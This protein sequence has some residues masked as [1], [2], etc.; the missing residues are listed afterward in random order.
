MSTNPATPGLVHTGHQEADLR[1]F[2]DLDLLRDN[3]MQIRVIRITLHLVHIL[4]LPGAHQEGHMLLL[5]T[6]LPL[7]SLRKGPDLELLGGR[8]Q[9][10]LLQARE[11]VGRL[12]GHKQ[13]ED[14]PLTIWEHPTGLR[15]DR[16]RAHPL[17]TRST[18]R[19]ASYSSAND[20][21]FNPDAYEDD[22][23]ATPFAVSEPATVTK[24]TEWT[25]H[26]AGEGKGVYYYNVKTGESTWDKPPGL[27]D[28]VVRAAMST[29]APKPI[30]WDT[31]E[32][33]EWQEV[34]ISDGKVYYYNSSTQA[35]SWSV[36][37][38]VKDARAA[39]AA[40][41]LEAT[42]E[43]LAR[44]SS[45]AEAIAALEAARRVGDSPL[46]LVQRNL[47][48]PAV[49]VTSAATYV[50][51]EDNIV[52]EEV[53]EQEE[54][55]QRK[56][57]FRDM[58][59]ERGVT[60]FSRW[61]KELPKIV[62]DQRYKAIPDIKERRAIFDHFVRN[63]AEEVR[64]E[65]RANMKAAAENF[66]ALLDETE[67]AGDL[68][69]ET[70][71]ETLEEKWGRDS[72]WT[73][74]EP[75]EREAQL[76]ERLLPVK[77]A[78]EERLGA[79]AKVAEAGFRSMLED[80]GVTGSSRWSKMKEQLAE[81]SRFLAVARQRREIIFR[82]YVA[83]LQMAEE[84]NRKQEEDRER[85]EESRR[86]RER[87]IRKRKE[88]EE[89]EMDRRREKAARQ[90]SIA[91]YQSLLTEQIKDAEASWRD[92]KTKLER[93]AQ[94]RAVTKDLSDADRERMFREH[95]A[96]LQERYVADFRTMLKEII[97]EKEGTE[98]GEEL[99]KSWD[100]AKKLLKGDSRYDRC[101]RRDR[102][103]V[104]KRLTEDANRS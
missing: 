16:L 78:E 10:H 34:K 58:L 86:Q 82:S 52:S 65:K 48:S 45:S 101:S 69:H 84:N 23:P 12:L 56:A 41:T 51:A 79:E 71:Y 61:E 83:E 87:E 26:N 74:I 76:S 25:V 31:I 73:S 37:D 59:V 15:Q 49:N 2:Q 96:S 72:R 7:D 33:C 20:I 5:H 104:Y 55:E 39:A 29:E 75:K 9:G 50:P 63:R 90:D 99:L 100:S 35:T 47:S 80:R 27:K 46:D 103:K 3:I 36:P 66:K 70:T 17:H 98:E 42:R 13:P 68:T 57:R 93:D 62:F 54:H 88:R 94:G 77:K 53:T 85:E 19:H 91:A 95:I 14:T 81:D 21:D 11:R 102:Q 44:A 1:V 22:E 97:R 43:A 64:K 32:G 30:S 92:S 24:E 4:V 89:E 40:K 28:E 60:P 8:L 18:A 38:E 6:I 67:A